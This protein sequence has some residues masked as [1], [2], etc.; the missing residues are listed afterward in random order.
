MKRAIAAALSGIFILSLTTVVFAQV[1][2]GKPKANS[3]TVAPSSLTT[4]CTVATVDTKSSSFSCTNSAGGQTYQFSSATVFQLGGA[5]SSSGKLQSG[6]NVKIQYHTS[7]AT[8][9]ADTITVAP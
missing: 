4:S 8:L 1:S 7:G 5:G 9:I 6:M 3:L 2:G